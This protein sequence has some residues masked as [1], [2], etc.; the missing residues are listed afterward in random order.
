VRGSVVTLS[1]QIYFSKIKEPQLTQEDFDV[2]AAAFSVI[3]DVKIISEEKAQIEREKG[4]TNVKQLN[5]NSIS[6]ILVP[7]LFSFPFSREKKTL[8][9][10]GHVAPRIWE[11]KQYYFWGRGH[12]GKN[13]RVSC[14]K[15]NKTVTLM[16]PPSIIF[17]AQS[18]VTSP[19]QGISP[20]RRKRKR[21]WERGCPWT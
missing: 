7:R 19:N 20:S 8:V 13:M 16:T 2:A 4:N 15:L 18:H 21:A 6:V 9:G 17:Y 10:A 3:F 11:V 5:I 1:Q 14:V 12:K